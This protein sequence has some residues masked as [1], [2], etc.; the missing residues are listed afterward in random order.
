MPAETRHVD[1]VVD[2][3]GGAE[4]LLAEGADVGVVLELDRDAEARLHLGRRADAVPAGQDALGRDLARRPVDRRGEAHPDAEQRGRARCPRRAGSRARARAARSRLSVGAWSTSAGDQSSA[5]S[6]PERSQ[7]A[8]RMC[9]WPKSRPT[10]KAAPGTSE[11]S[12]GG[13]PVGRGAAASGASCS[14]TTPALAE[15]LD[16]RRDRRPREPGPARE[17]GAARAGLAVE[18]LDDPQPVHLAQAQ[19]GRIGSHAFAQNIAAPTAPHG[20]DWVFRRRRR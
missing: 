19:R 18:H 5:T 15:L 14:S 9:W 20:R 1:E 7:I 12:T 6:S 4:D 13:R 10:A 2:A 11:S 3:A 16:E 8:T 17:V